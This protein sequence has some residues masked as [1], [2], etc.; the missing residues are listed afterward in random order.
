VFCSVG[1]DSNGHGQFQFNIDGVNVKPFDITTEH[2]LNHVQALQLNSLAQGPHN[3]TITYQVFSGH[4]SMWLDYI[5]THTSS[6]QDLNDGNPMLFFDDKSPEIQYNDGWRAV[7]PLSSPENSTAS[8]MMN[9]AQ[10]SDGN[11]S[12]F[13]FSFEG[14]FPIPMLA[15][16]KLTSIQERV[17]PSTA[18][19][20]LRISL[21]MQT[22]QK[23]RYL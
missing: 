13:S 10:A 6:T 11:G 17:F 9:T 1:G 7:D 14:M 8:N 4:P 20:P 15:S 12:A 18:N 3:M 21:P 23:H 5:M 2:G 19:Y 16:R 22:Q